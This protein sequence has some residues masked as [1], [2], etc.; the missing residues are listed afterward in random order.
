MRLGDP[1]NGG[2][3]RIAGFPAHQ[4]L[5][6]HRHLLLLRALSHPHREGFRTLVVGRGI[7]HLDGIDQELEPAVEV[8]VVVGQHVGAVETG[9]GPELGILQ[10]A[11]RA[12]RQR[13]VAMRQESRQLILERFRKSRRHEAFSDHLVGQLFPGQFGKTI[14]PDE[15]FEDFG[16]DHQGLRHKDSHR[17]EPRLQLAMAAQQGGSEGQAPGL[18]SQR[19]GADFEELPIFI[20]GP[21]IE[22]HHHPLLP[23]HAPFVDHRK[24]KPTVAVAVGEIIIPHRAHPHG[25]FDLGPGKQ[26]A[27]KVV[28]IAVTGKRLV[29]DEVQLLFQHFQIGG[30]GNFPAVRRTEHEITEAQVI[31]EKTAHFRKEHR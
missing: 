29:R 10:E 9:V 4:L 27:G 21:G 12:H 14:L 19:P 28:A 13:V 24:Q 7:D 1:G 3:E 15:G 17:L 8:G 5:D 11:G 6:D 16:G 18:A 30:A 31:E 25:Q 2:V 20:K 26:P 23:L 22:V